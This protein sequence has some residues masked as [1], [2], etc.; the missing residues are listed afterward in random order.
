MIRLTFNLTAGGTLYV[1]APCRGVVAGAKVVWQTTVTTSNIVTISRDTHTV[2]LVTAVTTAGLVVEKGVRDATYK[3]LVFDPA[4]TTAV[5]QVIKV[6]AS[7]GNS[8]AS[9][10]TIEFD[11][12]AYVEQPAKEA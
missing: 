1:P 3:D 7:G 8:V 6:V 2:N 9:V 12:Y 10:V 5:E 11:D 4:S